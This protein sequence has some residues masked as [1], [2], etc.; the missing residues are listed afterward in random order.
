M[1]LRDVLK[2]MFA[3]VGLAP[4]IPGNR[5]EVLMDGGPFFRGL[6]KA[7]ASAERYIFLESY[8]VVA[9][10]TGLKVARALIDRAKAGVEVAFII[11]AYGSLT[12]DPAYLVLLREAGVKVHVFRPIFMMAQKL[13]FWRRRNHR[14]LVVVDGK[15]GIVGGMNIS[16]DYAAPEDGG[17]DWHDCGV[18]VEG[19][20]VA[21]LEAMFRRLWSSTGEGA[22]VSGFR[23]GPTFPEGDQVR[24]IGNFARRDRSSIRRT[25]LLAFIAAERSIRITNAYFVPDRVLLRALIRAARRGVKVEIIVGAATDIKSIYYATRSLYSKM[26]KSGID[27][28]EWEERVLH[29]KIAVV[30]GS[31]CTIGSTNLDYFSSFRNLEVN[32]GILGDRIG[33]ELEDQFAVDRARSKRVDLAEWKKRPFWIKVIEW[34]AGLGRKLL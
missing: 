22:L 17:R 28:Y 23:Q 10:A 7:I 27:L 9:D 2:R 5:V 6:L 3:R 4:F 8:I 33:N 1:A 31:W 25:Y 26:L 21:A 16:D 29:A 32:A 12:L 34:F 20:A 13:P 24:F 30:D 18:R 11:D 14:K 15:V 19:P